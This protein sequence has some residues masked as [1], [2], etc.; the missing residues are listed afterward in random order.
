MN[1]PHV[2]ALIYRIDH[3]D[4]IDYSKAE[5]FSR[6][7][8]GFRLTV[9]DNRARFEFKE[10][11]ATVEKAKKTLGEYIRVWEIH[12]QL[13]HGP[14]SF[15]LQF[16]KHEIIDRK[17]TLPRPRKVSLSFSLSGGRETGG[18]K[19]TYFAPDYPEPPVNMALT[20]DVETMYDR[21]IGY[22]RGHEPLPSVAYFCF[23]VL[24]YV[25][26]H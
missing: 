1:D 15:R 19:L 24:L 16:D 3:R 14:N 10:H 4:T 13:E 8:Q 11:Y 5:P 17:P 25:A 2:V 23:T 6:D 18:G 12:V 20:P 26:D 7:E 22:K 9:E 21:Y